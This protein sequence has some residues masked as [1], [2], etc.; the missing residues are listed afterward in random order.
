MVALGSGTAAVYMLHKKNKKIKAKIL[1]SITPHLRSRFAGFS[2]LAS[3]AAVRGK[4]IYWD[5]FI[6]EDPLHGGV[7]GS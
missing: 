5:R 4:G 6:F 2:L 7:S 3:S 1:H